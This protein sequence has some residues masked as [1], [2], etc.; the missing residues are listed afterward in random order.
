MIG[1]KTVTKMGIKFLEQEG[2]L[3]LTEDIEYDGVCLSRTFTNA[4]RSLGKKRVAELYNKLP[5]QLK[6]YILWNLCPIGDKR[7]SKKF[8]DLWGDYPHLHR[9]VHPDR[10]KAF[11]SY[12]RRAEKALLKY[13]AGR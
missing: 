10:S 11:S 2:C 7:F 5:I 3:K 8:I 12:S 1:Y 9:M 6:I 4:V 13:L